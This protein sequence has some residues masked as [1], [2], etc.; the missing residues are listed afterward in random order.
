R[1][2][3]TLAAKRGSNVDTL[4]PPQPAVA[5]VAPFAGDC[6]LA[7]DLAR[8]TNLGDPV[9]EPIRLDESQG[10]SAV[11][12][13]RI[14][15]FLLGLDGQQAVEFDDRRLVRRA[16]GPHHAGGAGEIAHGRSLRRM[17]ARRLAS[18]RT[19]CSSSVRPARP[20]RAILA[21]TSSSRLS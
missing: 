1:A 8:A 5:P 10:D 12:H 13:G 2:E 19:R 9:A 21:S 4:K 7:G 15:Y 3:D 14:E 17:R 6:C 11:E 16:R 20:S 18:W